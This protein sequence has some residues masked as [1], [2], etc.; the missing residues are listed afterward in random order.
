MSFHWDPREQVRIGR[1]LFKWTFLASIVGMCAGTASAV[2]LLSLEFATETRLEQPW[3]LYLLPVAGLFVG[4]LYHYWGK[5]CERGN[6]LILEEIHDPKKGVSGRNGADDSAWHGRDGAAILDETVR[7]AVINDELMLASGQVCAEFSK[8][9]SPHFEIL[10][11]PLQKR[12]VEDLRAEMRTWSGH[13]GRQ[14]RRFEDW[15]ENRLTAELTKFAATGAPFARQFV[16]DAETRLRRIVEGFRDR[17]GRNVTQAL[18]LSLAPLSWDVQAPT[19]TVP[20]P[21]FSKTLDT[22]WEMLWWAI[23]MPLFGWFF[24]WHFLEVVPWEVDK[25]LRGLNAEWYGSVVAAVNDLREQALTWVRM[26]IAT[27]TQLL[28]RQSDEVPAIQESL[29]RLE[30]GLTAFAIDAPSN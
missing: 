24:H 23:P 22:S 4:V 11:G 7:E 6:N 20:A 9:V 14:T 1:Y 15:L 19:I 2:F 25:N 3:L 26:E 30:S 5:D 18:N 21:S 27:L 10:I 16:V 17:L 13:L 12:L 28:D 29:R 8:V